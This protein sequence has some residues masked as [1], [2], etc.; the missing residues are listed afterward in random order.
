MPRKHGGTT[1]VK[2]PIL[3]KPP[4]HPCLQAQM[5]RGGQLRGQTAGEGAATGPVQTKNKQAEIT[6]HRSAAP[7]ITQQAS[8]G[9]AGMQAGRHPPS[10]RSET[11]WK[12]RVCLPS[13]NSVSGSFF[14]A[15]SS[16]DAEVRGGTG[17]STERS[18]CQAYTVE[19]GMA[20]GR[21]QARRS[22]PGRTCE[23]ATLHS[24]LRPSASSALSA[25]PH[26]PGR[27]SW[28]RRGRR[29]GPCGARKC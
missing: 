5:G 7:T 24:T 22:Q 4:Q 17:Q 6:C 23:N 2:G 25:A 15:C 3:H 1:S 14:S 21:A 9:S 26:P 27:Q 20:C 13:P 28:R 16:G 19:Q 10:M 29:P 11:Y 8:R 18:S 12:E